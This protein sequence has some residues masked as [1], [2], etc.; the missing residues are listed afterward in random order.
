MHV[1]VTKS[2]EDTLSKDQMAEDQAAQGAGKRNQG[3]GKRKK[4]R[5]VEPRANVHLEAEIASPRSVVERVFAHIKRW[6]VFDNLQFLSSRKHSHDNVQSVVWI[7]CA[8]HNFLM[9]MGNKKC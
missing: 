7:S 9:Q 8:I 1:F 2:A 5:K 4:R 3:A 6:G